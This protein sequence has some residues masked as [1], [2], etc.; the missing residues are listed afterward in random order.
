MNSQ[1]GMLLASHKTKAKKVLYFSVVIFESDNLALVEA[2]RGERNVKEI[3]GIVQD[4]IVFIKSSFIQCILT[5]V[6]REGNTLAH[7]IAS[8]A[9]SRSLLGNWCMNPPSNLCHA[10]SRDVITCGRC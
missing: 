5:L 9:N 4:N 8:L 6:C 1:D 10:I 2:C 7:S 3:Q